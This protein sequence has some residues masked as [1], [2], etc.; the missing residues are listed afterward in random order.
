MLT[1]IILFTVSVTLYKN[2]NMC[3]MCIQFSI[4]IQYPYNYMRP[5]AIS[6]TV[7]DA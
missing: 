7:Y 3:V 6:S 4:L 1:F 5:L 2:K